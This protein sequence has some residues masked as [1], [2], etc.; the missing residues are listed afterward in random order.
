MTRLAE[1]AEAPPEHIRR[2]VEH[3]KAGG[4]LAHTEGR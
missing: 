3:G 1:R 2:K 4:D